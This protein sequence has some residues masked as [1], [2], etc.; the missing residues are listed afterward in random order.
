[1]QHQGA[2][3]ARISAAPD[4]HGARALLAAAGIPL[5]P[6]KR[7]STR[8]EALAAASDCGYPIVLK[9]LGRSHK[10][11]S[12]A[13]ILGLRD[14]AALGAAFDR[15]VE[16]LAPP[17]FSVEAMIDASAG[18][19]ILIGGLRDRGFGATVAVGLGGTLAELLN[20]TRVA[21]APVDSD[22]A[23]DMLLALK[24]AALL[25]GYRGR[26]QVDLAALAETVAAFS[27]FMAAHPEVTEAELNPVIALPAGAIAVDARIAL[28]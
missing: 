20:D 16:R 14:G 18:I 25:Q 19:E 10:S 26:P 23:C 22:Y 11:D 12:G 24:G 7:V 28:G 21:L 1:L 15:M 6:A 27:R 3:A 2:A 5:A 8:A 4:Y 17:A 13:V 9:G